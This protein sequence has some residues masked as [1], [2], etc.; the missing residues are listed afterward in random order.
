MRAD[1]AVLDQDL[2]AIPPAEIGSTSVV[3]TVAS[4]R[5]VYGDR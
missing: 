4:G 2:Y 3:M 5:V 1:V